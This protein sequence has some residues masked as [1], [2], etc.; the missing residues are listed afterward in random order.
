MLAHYVIPD[1]LSDPAQPADERPDRRSFTLVVRVLCRRIRNPSAFP[2]AR[3]QGMLRRAT[4]AATHK[5]QTVSSLSQSRPRL[6]E[7]S[8]TMFKVRNREPLF[9][10][11]HT[12][13][14]YRQILAASNSA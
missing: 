4:K 3:R 2:A 11:I 7:S 8:M 5:E 14:Q 6:V 13:E 12:S 10:E 1:F 9:C